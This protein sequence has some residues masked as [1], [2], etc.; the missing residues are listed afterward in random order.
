MNSEFD[1]TYL[2]DSENNF[3]VPSLTISI[4]S[5]NNYGLESEPPSPVPIESVI[6]YPKEELMVTSRYDKTMYY[7][8]GMTS[9]DARHIW[10][11][12]NIPHWASIW[13][14]ESCLIDWAHTYAK[15]EIVDKQIVRISWT[16]KNQ[17]KC[18]SGWLTFIR[19]LICAT[20]KLE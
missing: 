17:S 20:I 2:S 14:I 19:W 16:L 18:S 15:M 3:N 13:D 12:A 9:Y 7:M 4:N 1:N 8:P 6:D 5:E 10:R 11:W